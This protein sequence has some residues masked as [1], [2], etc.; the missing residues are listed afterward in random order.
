M[1][2]PGHCSEVI[3]A[4]DRQTVGC[5]VMRADLSWAELEIY[6]RGG[7]TR[8]IKLGGL[9]RDWHF[10]KDGEQLAIYSGP[11]TGP[12]TYALYDVV[13]ARIVAIQAELPDE[14][15]LP[16]WAESQAQI[17]DESVPTGA[18]LAQERTMWISKVLRQIDKIQ[19]GMRRG[20]LLRVF[21]TEGCGLGSN[22]PT[23]IGNAHTSRW[24]SVSGRP[25]RSTTP[26]WRT[27]TTSS[28]PFP[29]HTSPGA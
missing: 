17:A 24:M 2:G 8:T 15:L 13:S 7:Q 10:W 4:A 6:L 12:G 29:G 25:A 11:A 21:T 5:A 16:Q 26:S 1:A 9:I 27:P 23:S 28:R 22:A 20:D 3:V 14:S 18:A 19:P